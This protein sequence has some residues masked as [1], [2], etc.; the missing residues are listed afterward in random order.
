MQNPN[1]P[2]SNPSTRLRKS[3]TTPAHINYKMKAI[4]SK[5]MRIMNKRLIINT[6]EKI[7]TTNNSRKINVTIT[8]LIIGVLTTHRKNIIILGRK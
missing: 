5:T 4:H 1:K 2:Y 8:K 7:Q 6:K 3:W